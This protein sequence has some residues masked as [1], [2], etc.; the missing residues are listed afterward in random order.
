MPTDLHYPQGAS[1]YYFFGTLPV[2]PCLSS[3]LPYF[4]RPQL[5]E[6]TSLVSISTKSHPKHVA[7]YP[8]SW[9]G[10]LMFQKIVKH[11][12]TGH[13]ENINKK[14]GDAHAMGHEIFQN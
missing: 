10:H 1:R 14:Y 13:P 3:N 12:V 7:Y 5:A 4:H 9:L 2:W 8:T 11:A 6:L